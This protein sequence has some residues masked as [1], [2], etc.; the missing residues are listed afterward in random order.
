MGFFFSRGPG[1][2]Q[3]SP[4]KVRGMSPY[5]LRVMWTMLHW[6]RVIVFWLHWEKWLVKWEHPLD[7]ALL[8]PK[9]INERASCAGSGV[10]GTLLINVLLYSNPALKGS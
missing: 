6:D 4:V 5:E 7:T 1:F 3:L 8:L 2:E 10:T 9:S